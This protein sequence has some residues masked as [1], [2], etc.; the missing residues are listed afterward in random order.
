MQY[1]P[2]PVNE[3]LVENVFNDYRYPHLD[4]VKRYSKIVMKSTNSKE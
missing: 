3:D 2:P 4:D 1:D